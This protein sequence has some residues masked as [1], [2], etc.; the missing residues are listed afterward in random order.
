MAMI[1]M[2]ASGRMRLVYFVKRGKSKQSRVRAKRE[3][4]QTKLKNRLDPL[5]LGM[6]TQVPPDFNLGAVQ[7]A[8]SVLHARR[9]S[10]A[11]GR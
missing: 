11:S 7:L 6:C 5:W 10:T 8:V 4:P 2:G 9:W 1:A 3:L